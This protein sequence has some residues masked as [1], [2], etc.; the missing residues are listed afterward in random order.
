MTTP[1]H[2]KR[3]L[4]LLSLAG[5]CPI[6]AIAAVSAG[7]AQFVA[8]NVNVRGNDGQTR[9]LTKGQEIESGQVIFTGETGRAQVKFT[10]GGLVSLQ[11][12][13]QFNIAS[14]VDKDDPKEDRFIVNLLSGS[15]RAITGLIGKR[16]KSNYRVNISTSTI[17]IRGSSFSASL[18]PNGS[19]TVTA[20]KDAI[21][22]C[23]AGVCVG[24]LAGESVIVSNSTD[25]PV[26]TIN[27][28][29]IPTP[30]PAQQVQVVGNNTTADGRSILL[31]VSSS[32]RVQ[33][34]LNGVGL[35][36]LT[37]LTHFNPT[38]GLPPGFDA[39]SPAEPH[40]FTNGLLTNFSTNLNVYSIGASAVTESGYVGS[41]AGGDLM[42]WGSWSLADQ[43]NLFTSTTSPQPRLHYVTGVP[44]PVMPS[45]GILTYSFVGGSA[46]TLFN[47][48]AG[49][50]SNASTFTANYTA[51]SVSANIITSFG[52]VTGTALTSGSSFAT[53]S[54]DIKGFFSGP[55]ADNAGMVYYGFNAGAGG[56]YTGAVVFQRP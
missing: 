17:G 47:G 42:G 19:V 24:L 1:L 2:I 37:T 49:T 25:P 9:P 32:A 56:N 43:F 13:T 33:I 51:G 23:N 46:P 35:A 21:E 54:G 11:P 20:E 7:V 30:G 22:V 39:A 28:A 52:T 15:M 16:N 44:T 34:P 55:K 38:A 26:R 36:G 40:N 41:I 18:N 5:A 27:R 50:L 53:G 45:V 12:N 31:S 8:G 48:A 10:D 29:S 4:L 6:S 14:Y 3:S